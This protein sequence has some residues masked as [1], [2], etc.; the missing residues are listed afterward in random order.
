MTSGFVLMIRIVL[1]G[2]GKKKES[3]DPTGKR[4]WLLAIGCWQLAI[5]HWLFSGQMANGQ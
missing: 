2:M 1:A 5:V 4:D 3:V